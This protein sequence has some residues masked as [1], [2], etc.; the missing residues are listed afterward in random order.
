M[1]QKSGKKVSKGRT[2][3]FYHHGNTMK[4]VIY[5]EYFTVTNMNGKTIWYHAEK[6]AIGKNE[7]HF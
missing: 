5:D 4:L 6:A 2:Y 1:G 3:T 7:G